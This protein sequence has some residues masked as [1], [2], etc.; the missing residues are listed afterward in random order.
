MKPIATMTV[1]YLL[2]GV[3][4]VNLACHSVELSADE[5][6][7]IESPD[8]ISQSPRE[9]AAYAHSTAIGTAGRGSNSPTYGQ[10]AILW[11]TAPATG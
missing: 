3:I 7:H 9:L 8:Y 4:L 10:N 6:P 5:P 11:S 2:D 1:R